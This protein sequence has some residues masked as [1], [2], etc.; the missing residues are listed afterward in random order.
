MLQVCTAIVMPSG[1][2]SALQVPSYIQIVGIILGMI[3]IGY[4]GDRIG[5]KWG[6]VTTVSLMFVRTLRQLPYCVA[7]VALSLPHIWKRAW[8]SVGA[9]LLT[10]KHPLQ[11]QHQGSACASLGSCISAANCELARPASGAPLSHALEGSSGGKARC[12]V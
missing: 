9:L 5:R 1:A 12:A 7:Y 8:R 10:S 2:A 11:A 3:S 4:L 6:S